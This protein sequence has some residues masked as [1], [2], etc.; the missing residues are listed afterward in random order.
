MKNIQISSSKGPESLTFPATCYLISISS[1]DWSASIICLM[2]T[3]KDNSVLSKGEFWVALAND[4]ESIVQDH[5]VLSH[6]FC[7]F[8]RW[9]GATACKYDRGTGWRLGWGRNSRLWHP[10]AQQWANA[11]FLCIL[12][13]HVFPAFADAAFSFPALSCQL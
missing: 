1:I 4:N 13:R 3:M 6:T 12:L 8:S 10:E 7:L 5:G 2:K 11:P 9:T